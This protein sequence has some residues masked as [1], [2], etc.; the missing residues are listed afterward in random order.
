MQ[1]DQLVEAVQKLGFIVDDEDCMLTR[2]L[3]TRAVGL[4]IPQPGK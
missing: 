2:T 4:C 3:C 1:I